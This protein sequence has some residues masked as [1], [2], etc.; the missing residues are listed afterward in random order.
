[1][2]SLG[3]A[4]QQ[5][6]FSSA[7]G[8]KYVRTTRFAIISSGTSGTLTLPA[9]S[10]V[11]LDDFGGTTDAIVS[12]LSS[13]KPSFESVLTSGG[14]VVAA[15]FDISGNWALSG[16]PSAYPIAI[17]YR[18]R[19]QL[20]D[21]DSTASDILGGATFDPGFS[22]YV[23]KR[24]DTMTGALEIN[25]SNA[26]TSALQLHNS[27]EY[28]AEDIAVLTFGS[29][30]NIYTDGT[31]LGFFWSNVDTGNNRLEFRTE[32]GN[33]LSFYSSQL[34]G[35]YVVGSQVLSLGSMGVG[36][37]ILVNNRATIRG[38]GT[39]SSTYGLRVENSAASHVLTVRD[40]R[41][42]HINST[43]GNRDLNITG[44]SAGTAYLGF[45]IGSTQVMTYGS[46]GSGSRPFFLFDD[47]A[48]L[49]RLVLHSNGRFGLGMGTN[50]PSARL[51][52][53]GEGT[54]SASSG[55]IVENSS[56]T[57]ILTVRDDQL[58]SILG[59][60]TITNSDGAN[61]ALDITHNGG[62]VSRQGIRI[63][64]SGT[65]STTT[66]FTITTGN[67]ANA[68]T[69]DGANNSS[70][71]VAPQ[72]NTRL[73]IRGRGNTSSSTALLVEDSAGTD[74]F[75][76]RDDS[77]VG[78]CTSVSSTSRVNVLDSNS[79]TTGNNQ[80]LN[81][82]QNHTAGNT[83]GFPTAFSTLVN[84]VSGASTINF[85]QAFG[86]QGRTDTQTGDINYYQGADISARH[87]RAG[88][89]NI[90]TLQALNAYAQVE[91]ASGSGTIG[92]MRGAVIG[93]LYASGNTV[94]VTTAEVLRVYAGDA[95]GT[96][97]T[98][99]GVSI[100]TPTSGTITTNES[101]RV[102]VP[103][104]GTNRYG[105]HLVGATG[106]NADGLKWN[107]GDTNFWR[108]SAAVLRTD[109]AM[110][111]N[112]GSAV[113]LRISGA[114]NTATTASAGAQTLPSNPVGFLIVKID[115]TDRKVP[116]YA[117]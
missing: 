49:Y 73:V 57:D 56:G 106:T 71:G 83:A 35:D 62:T 29:D 72:S 69:V 46:D 103:T 2:G 92:S 24:G 102:N 20:K 50:S 51:Q 100:E 11:V 39:T 75:A 105:I 99:R 7:I 33:G 45:V 1:M 66:A 79:L 23:A 77:R 47:V 95:G 61:Y 44:A 36:A 22:D 37:S 101:L 3:F 32:A 27:R 26:L 6:G 18:V 91:S 78:I 112:S 15:T 86:V 67:A 81:V 42:V 74:I 21:F 40:D 53:M 84:A 48:G 34:I 97:T 113:G 17:I 13:S 93:L 12:R 110:F 76:V 85:M 54:T 31:P 94:N 109:G 43:S 90:T 63:T 87:T 14:A 60:S 70:F 41:K 28:F 58:V 98:H 88:A 115:G 5:F 116:Y 65:S 59:R 16:T 80:A 104:V 68:F 64:T 111:M 9:Y 10:Q 4:A 55:L 30:V 89:L 52:I 19:T 25:P 117:T 108:E 38:A 107:S 114:G 96:V 82:V 8:G